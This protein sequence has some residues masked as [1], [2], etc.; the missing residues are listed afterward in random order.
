MLD[1]GATEAVRGI[2]V[3]AEDMVEAVGYAAEV[4][5]DTVQLNCSCRR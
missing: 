4:V 5:E 2:V 3:V 1:R